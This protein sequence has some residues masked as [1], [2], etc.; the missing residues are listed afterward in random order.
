VD[1][2]SVADRS[3]PVLRRLMGAH[4]GVYRLTRG[5]IGHRFPGSPSILL[6]EHVGA[7]SG[8]ERTT[9]LLYVEDGD[10]LMIVASKGGHPRH[11]AWYHNLRA[12]P[13]TTV[14][15]GSER[16]PV[17]ARVASAQER[18]RLWP[19]AVEAYGGYR[20]YQQRTPREIPLVILEPRPAP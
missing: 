18:E 10:D 1:L 8:V 5:L 16:R 14:Q 9:P 15:V 7:K 13:D 6:L 17:R 2:L 19:M 3:W 12:H 4:A 20:S 11:P